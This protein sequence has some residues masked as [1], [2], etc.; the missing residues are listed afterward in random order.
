MADVRPG[1]FRE[2][3]GVTIDTSAVGPFLESKTGAILKALAEKMDYTTLMLI[4]KIDNEKLEGQVL[5]HRTG[6]LQRSVRQGQE[7]AVV[8]ADS[9]TGG[10]T[11]GGGPAWYG[12][13]HEYEG[14]YEAYRGR[15]V[16]LGSRSARR[17][18]IRKAGKYGEDFVTHVQ[19]KPYTIHFP[20]RSF[21]RST[22][23][24]EDD[25]IRGGFQ[26][27]ATEAART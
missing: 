23:T 25:N 26:D 11:G 16:A 10:V 21:M 6:K 7:L 17:M 13:L 9:V 3:I 2:Q 1:P 27:A 14:T 20:E 5:K 15:R 24:E 4:E 8:T 12:R 22:L 18:L 19:S